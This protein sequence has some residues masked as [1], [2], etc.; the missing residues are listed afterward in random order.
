VLGGP[1]TNSGDAGSKQKPASARLEGGNA[2]SLVTGGGRGAKC[3]GRARV[4]SAHKV[5]TRFRRAAPRREGAMAGPKGEPRVA[6]GPVGS[7]PGPAGPLGAQGQLAGAKGDQG[8][9][10]PP[11][12]RP[13]AAGAAGARRASRDRPAPPAAAAGA[14]C[15]SGGHHGRMRPADEIMISA[16]CVGW[17]GGPPRSAKAVHPAGKRLPTHR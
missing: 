1:Q 13:G 5:P 4:R 15:F 3:C 12:V 14:W 2:H 7:R 16:M 17:P 6:A 10:G 11:Q 9:P 8:P